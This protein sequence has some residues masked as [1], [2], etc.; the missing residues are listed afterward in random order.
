MSSL[1]SEE[2]EL[3]N[4]RQRELIH[5]LWMMLKEKYQKTTTIMQNDPDYVEM[6]KCCMDAGITSDQIV[7]VENVV[8]NEYYMNKKDAIRHSVRKEILILC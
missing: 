8:I 6:K 3:F 4:A 1:K 5:K 7:S 2:R